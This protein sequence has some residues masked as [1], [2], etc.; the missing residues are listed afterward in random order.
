MELHKQLPAGIADIRAVKL[1]YV[2]VSPDA[3]S[4][5]VSEAVPERHAG[6]SRQP[7]P[8]RTGVQAEFVR[9]LTPRMVE[10]LHRCARRHLR[11]Y[12]VS[13]GAVDQ[14]DVDDL[15]MG[16]LGDTWGRI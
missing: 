8:E 12:G 9:Q 10:R 11:W 1:T 15:V 13:G 7:W 14:A 3:C 4:D 16:V 2:P 6:T 5:R